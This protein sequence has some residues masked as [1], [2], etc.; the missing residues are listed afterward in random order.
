MRKK[1]H[2][3]KNVASVLMAVGQTQKKEGYGCRKGT[4]QVP[5]AAGNCGCR[6]GTG[7]V[8]D[9]K[10]NCGCPKNQELVN[11]NC[12]PICLGG[13]IRNAE[14]NCE[15]PP[16]QILLE[17][18]CGC[19][20]NQ[21]LV[22]GNCKPI[23][24]GGQTRNAAGKCQCPKGQE[25]VEGKCKEPG[26]WEKWWEDAKTVGNWIREKICKPRAYTAWFSCRST[27]ELSGFS[28]MFGCVIKG[29]A[30]GL[31]TGKGRQK[32]PC[33]SIENECHKKHEENIK[34]NKNKCDLQ[35]SQGLAICNK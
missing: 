26:F 33:K 19:P 25:L 1:R 32:E 35:L 10:G 4:G 6:E 27:N 34:A 13:Q 21:E 12:R 28:G 29:Y 20:K 11:G 14:G 2:Q 30:C 16:G 15:C 18:K 7:Q 5:D 24:L 31:K 9:A 17:G 22:N 8:Q 3:W 23:C